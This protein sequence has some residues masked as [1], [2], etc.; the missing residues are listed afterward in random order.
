MWARAVIPELKPALNEVTELRF[1][2]AD[3]THA[4][5]RKQGADW[6]VVERNFAADA[7]R[8]RKLLLDASALKIVE[9]KT[10]DPKRY[11]ELS[12]EDVA[13]ASPEA[14]VAAEAAEG[15]SVRLL[16]A[17]RRHARG[18]RHSQADVEPDQWQVGRLASRAT[19]A[20]R[21]I[22]RACSPVPGSIRMRT[23]SAGWT[24]PSSISRRRA[25]KASL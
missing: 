25:F 22:S 23:R 3:G 9:E 1:A 24:N 10:S 2:K 15:K 14:A 18:F 7:G 17:G 16:D 12:V 13:A 21:T 19:S 6:I 11:A 4:T 5:L 20:W 8:V